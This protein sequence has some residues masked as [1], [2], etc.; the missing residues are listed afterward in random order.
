VISGFKIVWDSR[1]TPGQRVLSV[2]LLKQIDKQNNYGSPGQVVEETVERSKEGRTYNIVTRD[3]M[4]QGHDGFIVLKGKPYLVDHE[5]GSIMS[6][7]VRQ[8]LLGES[9]DPLVLHRDS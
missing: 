2:T 9:Y 4:A 1:R 5:S 8:Y 3:Y 7:I 6:T